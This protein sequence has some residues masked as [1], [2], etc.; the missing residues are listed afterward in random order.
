M[1]NAQE[2]SEGFLK[3]IKAQQESF[4][5]LL[6]NMQKREA[7]EQNA[8]TAIPKFDNFNKDKEKWDHYLRRFDHYLD[9][10]GISSNEKK[11]ACLLSWVVLRRTLC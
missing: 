9:I 8:I 1:E 4:M 6:S 10:C 5:A 7:A 11:R 2:N 3:A